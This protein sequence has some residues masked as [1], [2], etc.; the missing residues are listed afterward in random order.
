MAE[1]RYP[2]P[3]SIQEFK[4]QTGVSDAAYGP[5]GGANVTSI[6][7][8]GSNDFH[9]TVFEFLRNEPL[10][11][12]DFFRNRT[13]Q[14]RPVLNTLTFAVGYYDFLLRSSSL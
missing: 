2:N 4:V 10:N 1:S 12:N 9:G 13:N 5:C 7:K 8:S 11:A 3:D 6:A 14:P